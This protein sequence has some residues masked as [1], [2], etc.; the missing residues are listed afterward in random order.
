MARTGVDVVARAHH[1]DV[2]A[3]GRTR[4]GQLVAELG[5]TLL[6]LAHV[7]YL[8]ATERESSRI[9]AAYAQTRQ[10]H[11]LL[12]QLEQLVH[13]LVLQEHESVESWPVVD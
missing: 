3:L 12:P 1:V 10:V 11:A 2:V 13:G 7:R 8:L 6:D 4:G 9:V 5:Q